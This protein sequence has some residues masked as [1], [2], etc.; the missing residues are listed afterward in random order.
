MKTQNFF[1]LVGIF[2]A[3]IVFQPTV[4]A[5]QEHQ[6]LA[7]T[8]NFVVIGA[9]AIPN[10]AKRF[11][12]QANKRNLHAQF[13]INPNR[14]LYYVYVLSTID[15]DKA[16][17]EA[18]R[19]RQQPEFS[20]AWVYNGMLGNMQSIGEPQMQSRG[21]DINPATE[22]KIENVLGDDSTHGTSS[23]LESTMPVVI[24]SA[25]KTESS[26]VE[27]IVDA[28][29]TEQTSNQDSEL[30]RGVEGANFYFKIFR[31][32]DNKSVDGDVD[33]IDVD[34]TRKI[35]TY[36]GNM[37]VKVSDP[38]S[39]S[40]NISL[41]CEVFG[42]RKVQHD[43]NYITPEGEDITKNESGAVQVPFELVRLQKGDI[44]VMYNVYFFKDAAIMR[45]ESHF[46]V[47]S[48]LEMLKENPNY[49]IKIHGHANGGAH[50]KIIMMGKDSKSFFSLNNTKDG[51]GSS[52]ELSSERAEIIRDYLLSNGIETNRMQIKAW[53]G[54]RPIHDKHST[55][56]QENVRVEIEILEN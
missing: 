3:F 45:P 10:N 1:A 18:L 37:G 52:K 7:E 42:Y 16:I 24:P 53:G 29:A 32:S 48:L 5:R 26:E 17:G 23:V 33:V 11:T 13:M 25:Q 41:M 27:Q 44:A 22:Q 54:K 14:N 4:A 30:D 51:Y 39:K 19:L 12:E 2:S 47:N 36:K 15:R 46:E 40:D 6:N 8:P 38:A 43:I 55:R 35:G 31:T 56:A 20:D 34:R 9:F 49:K 50:G 21:I 28:V